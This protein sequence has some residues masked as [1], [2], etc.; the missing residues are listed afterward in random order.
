MLLLLAGSART[1]ACTSAVVTASRSA[2]GHPVLWKHRDTGA[3]H[4]FIA[5]HAATDSTFEYIAL[6]NQGDTLGLE[7]WIGMNRAGLA[8]MNTASYNLAPDTA[9]YKDREGVVMTR[10][11]GRCVTVDDFARLLDRLPRPLGVQANFCAIDAQGHA[12]CFETCDTGYTRIDI[13]A[14]G[15]TFVRTNYSRSGRTGRKLGL[16]REK[17]ACH[18]L[19]GARGVTPRYL[20]DTLSASFY[21]SASGR[22]L[23]LTADTAA[24]DRGDLI[25]RY[26]STASI[27]IEAVP[28]AEGDGRNYIMWTRLGYPPAGET[29]PVTFG[30]IPADVTPGSDGITPVERRADLKKQE[31]YHLPSR[32]GRRIVDL[33]A[34]RRLLSR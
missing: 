8:V 22:D 17:A 20:T 24:V 29:Y 19:D 26:I 21:D 1:A 4:N 23:L 9:V 31:I 2:S 30:S 28:S 16:A 27:A 32:E 33:R 6:H 5:R 11:L 7:A 25:P 15:P 3:P 12:A 10:A 34:V 13:D 14:Q 18:F